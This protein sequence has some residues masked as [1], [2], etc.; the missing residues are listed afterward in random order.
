MVWL[1]CNPASPQNGVRTF[2]PDLKSSCSKL[3]P[4]CN[5][6]YS[7]LTLCRFNL[8]VDF[9]WQYKTTFLK[10]CCLFPSDR[11]LLPNTPKYPNPKYPSPKY[12]SPKY[13]NPKY[14]SPKYPRPKYPRPKYPRPKYPSPKYPRPK[15]PRLKQQ[16]Q[17]NIKC[18]LRLKVPQI[19]EC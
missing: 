13:P 6:F 19:L 10:N 4:E 17:L 14:P 2:H 15:Y 3:L 11:F 5:T 18:V 7:D 8:Y 1:V 16:Y 9:F 12:P